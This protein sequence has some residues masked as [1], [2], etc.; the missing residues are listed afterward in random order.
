M[1]RLFAVTNVLGMVVMMFG[2]TMLLPLAVAFWLDDAALFAYH[3]A[4]LITIFC[5][6]VMT[7]ATRWYR[8][9]LQVRDGFLLVVLVW[10]VLP[11]FATLPLL[12]FLPELSFTKAYFEAA[13]GLTASGGTV[14]TGLDML[15]PS[16]NLWRT[17]MVW[18]GGMG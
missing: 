3:Q 5:G 14:L 10:S 18:I 7:L 8:R 11:V 12:F 17:E 6:L 9:E 1:S 4:I 16:I 15:P 2:L 13:S